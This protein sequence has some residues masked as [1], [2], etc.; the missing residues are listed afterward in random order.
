MEERK[1]RCSMQLKLEIVRARNIAIQ[2]ASRGSLFVR[3]HLNKNIA[4][5]TKEVEA[6]PEPQWGQTFCLECEVK[7]IEEMLSA[8]IMESRKV[9]FELRWRRRIE[10]FGGL[11]SKVLG[12]LE[13]SWEEILSYPSLSI[14]KWVP[15]VEERKKKGNLAPSYD[16][17]LPT[18]ALQ[19]G[20]W[21]TDVQSD[22]ALPWKEEI[23]MKS[24]SK[25]YSESRNVGR[26]LE[27]EECGCGGR[28]CIAH[29]DAHFFGQA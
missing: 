26:R 4:V 8:L 12:R 21:V 14:N 25:K 15:L 19:I 23:K 17:P 20:L 29:E 22:K 6:S 2:P 7:G 11:K 27:R 24:D 16:L 5:D 13:V 9:V 3:Y 10:V 28:A 18:S 1:Q